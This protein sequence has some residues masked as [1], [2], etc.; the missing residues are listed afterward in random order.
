MVEM[1]GVPPPI[2]GNQC[3]VTAA[4][5]QK[6]TSVISAIIK[7]SHDISAGDA[8]GSRALVPHPQRVLYRGEV[9]LRRR[10]IYGRRAHQEQTEAEF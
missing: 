7:P 4:V 3:S 6:A 8:E 10:Q 5:I 9:I 2:G 1:A